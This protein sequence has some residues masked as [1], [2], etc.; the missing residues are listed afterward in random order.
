M[1]E[2]D[3]G[4][5]TSYSVDDAYYLSRRLRM[6]VVYLSTVEHLTGIALLYRGP[7]AMTDKALISSL[8]EQTGIVHARLDFQDQSINA[9]GI[10]LGLSDEDT[11]TQVEEALAFIGDTESAVF[12][13]D[14]NA[15]Y[16]SPEMLAVRNAGF[17]D[18]F[19]TL[20]I[21]PPP[22]TAPAIVPTSR[23]DFVWLRGL[24]PNQA[25]ASES[26]ASDHRMVAVEVEIP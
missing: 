11:L 26:L 21:D 6:N 20:G 3:T 23:I 17:R 24:L 2:V 15:E 10:W 8:Q 22:L 14:F 12:G 9:Y 18:P 16:D 19:L 4:R 25:W 13:G 1:Q 5:I 7:I